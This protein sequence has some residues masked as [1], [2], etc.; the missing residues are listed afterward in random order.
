MNP[1]FRVWIHPGSALNCL[2]QKSWDAPGWHWFWTENVWLLLRKL[3][4]IRAYVLRR[5][6]GEPIAYILGRKEF[7]G[8]DFSVTSDV[9]IPRPETEHIIEESRALFQA[10]LG[11][12]FCR[13]RNRGRNFGRDYR[14]TV[15]SSFWG[16][17]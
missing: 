8:I 3:F 7:Y 11:F 4:L 13:F 14:E 5:A 1:A 15:F 9:L 6:A 17:G 16:S 12:S 2:W 10:E